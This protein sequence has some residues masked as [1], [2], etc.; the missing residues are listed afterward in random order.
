MTC[1][2]T[3]NDF[4]K[5]VAALKAIADLKKCKGA[6]LDS[7]VELAKVYVTAFERV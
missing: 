3:T 2:T 7:A 5:A 1:Y 6:T 4:A